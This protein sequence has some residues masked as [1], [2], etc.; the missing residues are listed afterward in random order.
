MVKL[1]VKAFLCVCIFAFVANAFAQAGNKGGSDGIHQY[2][3]YTQGKWG[4]RVGTSGF[5][6]FD[7]YAY[8][9]NRYYHIDE[10]DK[11][12]G[13]TGGTGDYKV[14]AFAP[15]MEMM[16][17]MEVGLSK[18]LDVGAYL[19]FYGDLA[20]SVGEF[21]GKPN[22]AGEAELWASGPGDLGLWTKI[23]TEL[24]PEDFLFAA[25]FYFEF[26]LPTGEQ[27]YG[28]RVRHPWYYNTDGGY[29]HPFTADE[30]VTIPMFI[31]TFD[32][33]KKGYAPLRW[34]NYIGLAI[35]S[36]HGANTLIYGTAL[37][38]LPES[39]LFEF[40][41]DSLDTRF[42]FEFHGESRNQKTDLPRMP[43]DL[44]ILT[45]AY[46]VT[47]D[48][49]KTFELTLAFEM[50]IKAF[51]YLFGGYDRNTSH[52]YLN[53]HESGYYGERV[54]SNYAISATPFYGGHI[55]LSVHFGKPE[56]PPE[57]CPE[58]RIDTVYVTKYDTVEIAATCPVYEEKICPLPDLQ[59][60]R[61]SIHFKSDS[62]ELEERSKYVLDELVDLMKMLPDVNVDL[63]GHTD[64]T[65]SEDYN[66]KLSENR[67]RSAMKYLVDNGIDSTRLQTGW[68]GEMQPVRDNGAEKGRRKNR[69]VELLPY[70]QVQDKSKIYAAEKADGSGSDQYE[71]TAD[72]TQTPKDS[73]ESDF[74]DGAPLYWNEKDSSET[75]SSTSEESKETSPEEPV[76]D[77]P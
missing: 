31:G 65:A 70:N 37:N 14:G 7:S 20:A 39:P 41:P 1:K 30:P 34:N 12:I 26:D 10:N 77:V 5:G 52:G 57:P 28:M 59:Y 29:T 45:T 72:S 47:F 13:I 11:S 74:Y 8:S 36:G 64:S 24:F 75:S 15:S 49:Q 23:R 9:G 68:S 60:F 22:G 53:Q 44:D 50:S 42:F 71:H 33:K 6:T 62:Y 48:F 69:R 63:F 61:K 16:F 66:V 58:P 17:Y 43:L 19:P 76:S 67:A 56:P 51:A 4:V 73:V 3:A 27:G 54:T 25:A 21:F 32:F 40:F 55:N 38:I 35:A 18:Y 2:N 46:G